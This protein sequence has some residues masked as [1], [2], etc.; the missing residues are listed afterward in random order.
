M[1]L[2]PGLSTKGH[3]RTAQSVEQSVFQ[4]FVSV[5]V[6][7]GLYHVFESAE[8]K[9]RLQFLRQFLPAGSTSS[10][11]PECQDIYL[12]KLLLQRVDFFIP[13]HSSQDEE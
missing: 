2:P 9:E 3:T 4:E 12:D 10:Y 1:S 6:K 5:K 7:T 8:S 11:R 13:F